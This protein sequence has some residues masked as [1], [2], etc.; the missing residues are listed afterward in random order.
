VPG[1]DRTAGTINEYI[2]QTI[3]RLNEWLGAGE[4]PPPDVIAE[5]GSLLAVQGATARRR[6]S[7]QGEEVRRLTAGTRHATDGFTD[8]GEAVEGSAR[9]YRLAADGSWVHSSGGTYTAGT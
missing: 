3:D 1:G 7:R 4:E 8:G 9:W 5:T 2:W 6:P